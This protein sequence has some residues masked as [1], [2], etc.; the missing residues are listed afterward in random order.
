MDFELLKIGE[1]AGMAGVSVKALYIYE[2]KNI[3]KPV[4]ID[5]QNGY[6]YYSADQVKQVNALLNLKNLGFSLGEIKRIMSGSLSQDDIS[7]IIDTKR[8]EW[9]EEIWKAEAHIEELNNIENNMIF[10]ARTKDIKSM[11]DEERAWYISRLACVNDSN[12]KNVISEAI[13][14]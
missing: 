11:S 12:T 6:R 5:E 8:K 2:K 3:I 7:I 14:L 13:W 4:K 10:D 9:Q 1:L